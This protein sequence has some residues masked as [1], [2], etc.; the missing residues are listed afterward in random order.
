MV[1]VRPVTKIPGWGF[2]FHKD[3]LA[4]IAL[5]VIQRVAHHVIDGIRGAVDD[6]ISSIALT[7]HAVGVVVTGG[8]VF[9][10]HH[11]PLIDLILGIGGNLAAGFAVGFLEVDLQTP[12]VIFHDIVIVGVC[13]YRNRLAASVRAPVLAE[14]IRYRDFFIAELDAAQLCF[15]CRNSVVDSVLGLTPQFRNGGVA[16]AVGGFVGSLL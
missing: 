7:L 6:C 1:D 8:L 12:L 4:L 9:A 14:S 5:G 13:G 15:G 2:G 11:I 10:G 16:G 3:K